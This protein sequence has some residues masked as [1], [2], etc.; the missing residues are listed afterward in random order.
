MIPRLFMEKISLNSW[1]QVNYQAILKTKLYQNWQ[2]RYVY[3]LFLL[4]TLLTQV[5]LFSWKTTFHIDYFEVCLP[6]SSLLSGLIGMWSSMSTLI[7]LKC[8]SQFSNIETNSCLLK[9]LRNYNRQNDSFNIYKWER[10]LSR[11]CVFL[12][13][14]FL[15]RQKP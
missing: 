6:N 15:R 7:Q 1:W 10:R 12:Q 8:R 14:F 5:E 13:I 2:N 3:L 9:I 4:K 11:L